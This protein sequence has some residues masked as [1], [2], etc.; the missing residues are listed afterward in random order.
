MLLVFV[1]LCVFW[2]DLWFVVFV[3]LVDVI[4]MC[5]VDDFVFFGGGVF[6][7]DVVWL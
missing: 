4:Y 1:N 3:C 6:V 2:F 5:Y 7:C